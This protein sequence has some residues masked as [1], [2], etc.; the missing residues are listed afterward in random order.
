MQEHHCRLLFQDYTA[1]FILG[2]E[3]TLYE[4]AEFIIETLLATKGEPPVQYEN[5]EE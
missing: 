4:L 2:G 3:H 1:D 5:C